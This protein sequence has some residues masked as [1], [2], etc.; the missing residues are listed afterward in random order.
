MAL[1]VRIVTYVNCKRL[2]CFAHLSYY[3]YMKSHIQRDRRHTEDDPIPQPKE[4]SKRISDSNL[5]QMG[6][7]VTIKPSKLEDAIAIAKQKVR[8]HQLPVLAR[9]CHPRLQTIN[10]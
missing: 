10:S 3:I 6:R 1:K 8:N 2:P 4:L 9:D 5:N 7:T